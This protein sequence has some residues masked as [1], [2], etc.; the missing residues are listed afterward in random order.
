MCIFSLRSQLPESHLL[1]CSQSSVSAAFCLIVGDTQHQRQS[2]DELPWAAESV[3]LGVVH[4][5]LCRNASLLVP[6]LPTQPFCVDMTQYMAAVRR[7]HCAHSIA[8]SLATKLHFF[9]EL[10]EQSTPGNFYQ[11]STEFLLCM[12]CL[13]PIPKCPQESS[14]QQRGSQSRPVASGF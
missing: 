8:L 1:F 7:G 5:S 12:K 4:M 14:C 10:A 3:N 6:C 13:F 9:A 11:A 2:E